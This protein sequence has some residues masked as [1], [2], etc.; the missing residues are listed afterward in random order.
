MVSVMDFIANIQDSMARELVGLWLNSS[1]RTY[2]VFI[3]ASCIVAAILWRPERHLALTARERLWS[4]ETWLSRSAIN[5]YGLIMINAALLAVLVPAIWPDFSALTAAMQHGF[6]HILPAASNNMS[7][8]APVLLALTL[9]LVDDLIRYGVHYAE[10]RVPLLWQFHKVHHSA[11]VLNFMTAERHHPIAILYTNLVMMTG[12]ALVNGFFIV[13]FGNHLTMATILG[14]NLFWVIANLLGSAFRHS[15]V[16]ISFGPKLERWLISPAQH[17]IH[18][19]E[20]VRHWDKNMGGTLA[21]WD[22]MFG[23]L[24]VTSK[25][26]ERITFGIGAETENHAS[27]AGIYVRPLIDAVRLLRPSKQPV[28]T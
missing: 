17:Q 14:G 23:T 11:T 4:K 20:D 7:F 28:T 19:S 8:T 1:S 10:H 21:V 26:R 5:D 24:Y 3:L 25:E 16:W 13:V 15:P 2:W 12:V 6:A 22:R 18:H 9:F 27:L